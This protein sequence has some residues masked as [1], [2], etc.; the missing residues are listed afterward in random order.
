[1]KKKLMSLLLTIMMV[2][3][4][5]PAMSRTVNADDTLLTKI[6][7]GN[8]DTAS[9]DPSGKVSVETIGKCDHDEDVRCGIA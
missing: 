4:M 9:Q 2:V 5:L 7:L 6:T 8:S 3:S 1:M